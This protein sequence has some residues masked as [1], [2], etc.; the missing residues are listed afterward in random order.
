[1]N[2]KILKVIIIFMLLL[3]SSFG[4]LSGVVKALEP[5]SDVIYNGID[6]STYQGKIDYASVKQ[7]GIDVVYIK[8][9]EGTTLEDPYFR[10]NYENAKSNG[11]KVGFYHFVRARSIE[12]AEKEA[13]FFSSVIYGTNPDCRLAMDFETF[14]YLNN[15]EINDISKVFLQRVIN[16]TK[17]QMVIY[18][19]TYNA[20]NIFNKELASQYPLW[21][22][23]Y[24]VGRPSDNGNWNNWVG[25]QYTDEGQIPGIDG[26]VD[27]DKFT[28]DIFLEDNIPIPMPD[29]SPDPDKPPKYESNIYYVVKPGDTLSHI[30]L[31]YNTTVEELVKLNDIQNPNLIYVEQKILITTSGDPN[32]ETHITYVVKKGD[33]LTKLA[34][35]YGTTINS[36]VKLNNIENP[37][38]IYIGQVLTIDISKRNDIVQ[39][40][41][42]YYRVRRGDSLWRIAKRYHTSV[43]YL[44]KLNNIKNPNRIY[45]GQVLTISR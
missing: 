44:V 38:L 35:R 39:N 2:S 12:E 21:V 27:R 13:E 5:S 16:L 15:D 10:I 43:S 40:S 26:Y 18:S 20:R 25:F 1:M 9:S 6:V 30:A 24:G 19:D 3:I 41:P 22:A 29:P 28:Q 37:N 42:V 14:G 11:M 23:Q 36:I 33:T 7:S 4:L 32:K 17:K 45:V 8:A 31:W 34:I